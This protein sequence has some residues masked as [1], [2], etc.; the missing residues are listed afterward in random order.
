MRWLLWNELKW[1]VGGGYWTA[2][3]APYTWRMEVPAVCYLT[4][5][6]TSSCRAWCPCPVYPATGPH[7]FSSLLGNVNENKVCEQRMQMFIFIYIE[8]NCLTNGMHL[9]IFRKT[10]GRVSSLC[11]RKHTV[12]SHR[13]NCVDSRTYSWW[14]RSRLHAFINL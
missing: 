10:S 7:M 5:Q 9:F 13:N 2:H 4:L 14:Y 6:W 11:Q 1:C 3:R 8:K 12:S